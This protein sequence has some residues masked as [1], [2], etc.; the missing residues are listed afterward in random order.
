MPTTIATGTQ[1]LRLP[2]NSPLP[3]RLMDWSA[4]IAC[5]TPHIGRGA[6]AG[7][8]HRFCVPKDPLTAKMPGPFRAGCW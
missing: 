1:L 2:G 3:V 5:S 7:L 8:S 4:T 6:Q